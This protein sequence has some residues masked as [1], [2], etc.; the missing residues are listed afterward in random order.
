MLEI[1]GGGEGGEATTSQNE[2]T[3]ETKMKTK[4]Q[5]GFVT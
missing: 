3:V 2:V 1:R 5:R 4:Q